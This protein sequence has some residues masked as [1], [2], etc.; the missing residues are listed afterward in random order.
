MLRIRESH[1]T[2]KNKLLCSIRLRQNSV[3]PSNMDKWKVSPVLKLFYR[4][5]TMTLREEFGEE[6]KGTCK[7][8]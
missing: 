7:F 6:D 1:H 5:M 3:H 4:K 2:R 8:I